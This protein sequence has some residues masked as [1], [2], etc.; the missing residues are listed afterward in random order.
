MGRTLS[1]NRR[2]EFI[3]DIVEIVDWP[4]TEFNPQT[5]LN[6]TSA[7]PFGVLSSYAESF[8]GRM[9][10]SPPFDRPNPNPIKLGRTEAERTRPVRNDD[11]ED[12]RREPRRGRR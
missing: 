4:E 10:M 1:S 2:G 7:K 3:R 8:D 12:F 5:D 9:D 11:P 6:D